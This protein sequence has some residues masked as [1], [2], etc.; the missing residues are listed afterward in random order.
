MYEHIKK[1]HILSYKLLKFTKNQLK[2]IHNSTI[3]GTIS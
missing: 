1:I 2:I 3:T